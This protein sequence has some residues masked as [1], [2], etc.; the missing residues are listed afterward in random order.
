MLTFCNIT[1]FVLLPIVCVCC[2]ECWQACIH[3]STVC[4]HA[5]REGILIWKDD[6]TGKHSCCVTFCCYSFTQVFIYL[7][8]S[9]DETV[10]TCFFFH[11]TV[12][13]KF[14]TYIFLSLTENK[15]KTHATVSMLFL[16][17][18][19]KKKEKKKILPLIISSSSLSVMVHIWGNCKGTAKITKLSQ[20]KFY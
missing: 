20:L 1:Q 2:G 11:T 9:F 17:F 13:K 10:K 3:V 19:K 6:S 15:G 5:N 12:R 7:F 14:K 8:H 4:I 18:T 16:S